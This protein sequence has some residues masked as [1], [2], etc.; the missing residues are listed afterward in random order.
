MHNIR[1][2]LLSQNFLANPR[3]VSRLVAR[4]SI[5]VHDLVLEIG[6]GQGIITQELVKRAAH[7][8]AVELDS[9]WYQHLQTRFATTT[10]LTLYHADI[11]TFPVPK[12]PYKVFA[13][14]PFAIEGKIIRYLIENRYPPLDCYL[15]V[16]GKLAER[17]VASHGENMFSVMHK[18]WFD[19]AIEH[20]FTPADFSPVPSVIPVLFRFS[21]KSTPLLPWSERKKYQRFIQRGFGHGQSVR[22][23][24]QGLY[25][26]QKIDFALQKLSISHKTKPGQLNLLHWITL[27]QMLAI[28]LSYEY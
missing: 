23:N 17:L 20:R 10:N 7:V 19:F 25:E 2:K 4:S 1:R 18:P 11:L 8:V 3:L 21:Q 26:S 14:I 9:Y 13:N 22:H 12:L 28:I 15:V 5:G 24:L 16:M 6:P 27:Y